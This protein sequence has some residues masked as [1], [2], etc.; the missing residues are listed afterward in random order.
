MKDSLWKTIVLICAASMSA[1]GQTLEAPP[2]SKVEIG[3]EEVKEAKTYELEVKDSTGNVQILSSQTNTLSGEFTCG[4]YSLRARTINI[5]DIKGIWGAESFFDVPVKQA[6]QLSPKNKELIHS[7]KEKTAAVE[8]SWEPIGSGL[9]YQVNV[10]NEKEELVSSKKSLGAK[11][12]LMLPVG[13][14]Y[15]WTLTT[16]KEGCQ[17]AKSEKEN[18]SF[19]LIGGLK[20]PVVS[21]EE[22]SVKWDK[23]AFAESFDYLVEFQQDEKQQRW[24]QVTT[25]TDTSSTEFPLD[26]TMKLGTYRI[27]VSARGPLREKS[28]PTTLVFK[29]THPRS[30]ETR[31]ELLGA[32]M[33]AKKQHLITANSDQNGID[34]YLLYNFMFLIAGFYKNKGMYFQYQYGD[35]KLTLLNEST[36]QA[37]DFKFSLTRSDLGIEYD[38]YY[39]EYGLVMKLYVAREDT[40]IFTFSGPNINEYNE[41]VTL[42]GGEVGPKLQLFF[43]QLYGYYSY[44]VL[45]HSQPY[46]LSPYAQYGAGAYGEVFLNDY[47]A[48]GA[49]FRYSLTEY[50]YKD[51]NENSFLNTVT[52]EKTGAYIRYI[53]H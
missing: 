30:L 40:D 38:Y 27:T 49:F 32:Y 37:V 53:L 39:K 18:Y 52:T 47:F 42:L 6:T 1:Y 24:T 3:L 26:R 7:K 28:Q 31:L 9:S 23:P 43:L 10:Y 34:R 11:T 41:T 50:S 5:R 15:T 25:K 22:F 20:S 51:P 44:E 13:A 19:E 8:F 48:A 17:A 46:R 16:L 4:H 35:K 14:R 12:N 21:K 29:Y 45:L 33:P 36:G 2:Q